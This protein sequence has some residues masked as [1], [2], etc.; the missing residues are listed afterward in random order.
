LENEREER[1]RKR[2]RSRSR[3]NEAFGGNQKFVSKLSHARSRK[4]RR[5]VG[6]EEAES[7]KKPINDRNLVIEDVT[8]LNT[9]YATTK[10][11]P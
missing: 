7:T 2:S 4:G 9:R 5:R 8:P 1:K 11:K 10:C 6:K 3:T